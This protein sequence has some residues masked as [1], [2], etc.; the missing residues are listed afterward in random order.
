MFI[1]KKYRYPR[2]DR[3]WTQRKSSKIR[4]SAKAPEIG[5]VGKINAHRKRPGHGKEQNCVGAEAQEQ[6][7][8]SGR[9]ENRVEAMEQDVCLRQDY[10]FCQSIQLVTET[11]KFEIHLRR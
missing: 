6:D 5:E 3:P 2:V 9:L 8:S 1:G 7:F 4:E 10:S 11:Q